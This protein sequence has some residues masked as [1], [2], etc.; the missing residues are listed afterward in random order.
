MPFGK[1]ARVQS[2][3]RVREMKGILK[4]MQNV[5]NMG[6][7]CVRNADGVF[8]KHFTNTVDVLMFARSDNFLIQLSC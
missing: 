8:P 2:Q 1:E 6:L 7:L 3:C 4:C 5:L